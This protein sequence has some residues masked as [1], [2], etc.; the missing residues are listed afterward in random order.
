MKRALGLTMGLVA[1]AA[2]GCSDGA[3]P[4]TQ[5]IVSLSFATRLP[6]G[7][8]PQA[9]PGASQSWS[10]AMANDTIKDGTN[11]LVITSAQI[12]LREI[13]LERQ[14]VTDCDVEPEPAGCEDFEIGPVLVSL[15]LGPGATEQVAV[16][17]P[18]G[19]YTEVEF[20]IHKV[21]SDPED[22]AF[23]AA[24]P[25]FADKS[26]RVQGTFNGT[27]FTFESD[28]DVE[29][30]LDLVP[31]LVIAD[32]LT[33]TNLTVRVGLANWFRG[34]DGKLV[35]PATANKGGANEGIVKENIKQSVEAF[36]DHDED[37]DEN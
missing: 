12:V 13:E 20:E 34:S 27:P 35:N 18:P 16:E 33:S 1:V 9:A 10:L 26:I 4:G 17:V 36:E 5:P 6:S 32:S 8:S 14:E 24:H 31:P 28:L 19:T 37:G 3:G 11:T 25:E 29:Q 15:P 2:A 22:A 23:R 7:M 21:S 30:E